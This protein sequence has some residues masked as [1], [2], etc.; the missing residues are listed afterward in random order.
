MT[1]YY[2]AET[3]REMFNSGYVSYLWDSY[4][5]LQKLI[6]KNVDTILSIGCGTA[7]IEE[8]MPY[9]FALYDPFGPV[10][11]YRQ[12]P[13]GQY[14]Y[15]IAHGCVMSAAEPDEKIELVNLG[16]SHA[17]KFLIHTGYKNIPH[18]D[19]CMTYYEWDENVLLKTFVW[20]KINKS[21]VEVSRA[22]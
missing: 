5:T 1:R 14:D 9:K 18:S 15:A 11:E 20:R 10:V 22:S 4:R 2:S 21:Y 16:L 6:P 19:A 3:Y 7:E 8:L 12:K 13:V 17:P